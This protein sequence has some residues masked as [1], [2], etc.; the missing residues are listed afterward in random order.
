MHI[1]V[2]LTC[3]KCIYV[4]LMTL[5]DLI[6]L[7]SSLFSRYISL[8]VGGISLSIV[9]AVCEPS[10]VLTIRVIIYVKR[11]LPTVLISIHITQERNYFQVA[12]IFI[13]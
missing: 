11:Y 10:I 8:L 6:F 3:G 4:Y 7:R 13:V 12:G 2:F 5:Y 9:V 1:L